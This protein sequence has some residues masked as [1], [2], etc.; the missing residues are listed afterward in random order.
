MPHC[1]NG[2]DVPHPQ[3]LIWY[4][5]QPS[6]RNQDMPLSSIMYK[7]KSKVCCCYAEHLAHPNLIRHKNKTPRPRS[8]LWKFIRSWKQITFLPHFSILCFSNLSRLVNNT[9]LLIESRV[10]V[11]D[12]TTWKFRL[13][14]RSRSRG[15]NHKIKVSIYSCWAEFNWIWNWNWRPL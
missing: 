10:I 1:S 5:L 14:P 4:A 7:V 11:A 3:C 8:A 9:Q 12:D 6:G 13:R 2:L 15:L